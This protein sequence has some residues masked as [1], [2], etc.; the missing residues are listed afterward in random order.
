M[1][2]EVLKYARGF[3]TRDSV[4]LKYKGLAFSIGKC[5]AF[6]N[7]SKSVLQ[8]QMLLETSFKKLI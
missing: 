4:V 8:N 5:C 2:T 6:C 3:G 1:H 7:H